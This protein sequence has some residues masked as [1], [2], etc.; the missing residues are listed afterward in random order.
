MTVRPFPFGF[1]Y[2]TANDVASP[3]QQLGWAPIAVPSNGQLWVSRDQPVFSYTNGRFTAI[4]VGYAKFLFDE[5]NSPENIAEHSVRILENGGWKSFHEALDIVVGRFAAFIWEN[6]SLRIYHD[7]FAI[8]PVYFNLKDGLVTSHAP[9]LRELREAA[10]KNLQ[11]LINLGQHKLWEETEDPDV[12]ALPVDFFLGLHEQAIKRYYPHSPINQRPLSDNHRI[13]RASQL[14]RQSMAFWRSTPL[15]IHCALTGGLDTR[16]NAA[17]VLGSGLEVNYLTYGS[18]GEISEADSRTSRSYKIDFQITTQIS[19]ALGLRHTLLPVQDTAEHKLS[20]DELETLERNTFRSHAVQFQGLYEKSI[21][22]QL[23]VCFVGTAF[24]G[25]RDYFVSDRRPLSAF[26]E[27]MAVVSSL[28]GFSIGVR[29]SELTEE[30]AL[31]YW[32][33][34]EFQSAV[35]NGH[36]I[37]NLLFTSLRAGRFQ[38]EAINC[39]ATA[40]MPVNPLAI[41]QLFEQGQAFPYLK[42]KNGDFDHA[43]IENLFPA[44]SAFPVNEKPK[45]VPI[46][47]VPTEISIKESVIEDAGP[48]SQ[49]SPQNRNDRIYL[50]STLLKRGSSKSFERR[51]SLETGALDIAIVNNYFLGRPARNSSLFISVNNETVASTPIGL[52]RSPYHFHVNGLRKGDVIQAGIRANSDLGTAWIKNTT[53]DLLEWTELPESSSSSLTVSSTIDAESLPD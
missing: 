36:P 26:E 7:P 32:N 33:R 13:S 22:S 52:R 38:N 28:G 9:L 46:S 40:F 14:A 49:D 25:M 31:E 1:I 8:R 15:P 42:R 11:P 53:V 45:H 10:G 51:F 18:H 39:Q 41:R 17:A 21:G 12:K 44:I 50:D 5:E 23:N 30:I 34:Y 2:S 3:S 47:A 24:E 29:E 19:K 16:I 20:K 4:W 37:G 27:F 6:E 35:E 43:L 48:V